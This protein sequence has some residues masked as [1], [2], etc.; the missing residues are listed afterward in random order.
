MLHVQSDAGDCNR[1]GGTVVTVLGCWDS[2]N[3]PPSLGYCVRDWGGFPTT[4]RSRAFPLNSPVILVFCFLRLGY[5]IE[6]QTSSPGSSH[7]VVSMSITPSKSPF[8]LSVTT[9]SDLLPQVRCRDF[10]VVVL[11]IIAGGGKT[12]GTSPSCPLGGAR[13]GGTRPQL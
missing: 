10:L 3:C 4:T 13:L 7:P 9:N 1:D 5:P 6:P 8:L 11:F 2:G 12:G